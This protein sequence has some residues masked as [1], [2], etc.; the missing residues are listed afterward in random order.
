MQSPV[1]RVR[2]VELLLLTLHDGY[3]TVRGSIETPSGVAEGKR[4][5]C[6]DCKR[7]GWLRTRHGL[8][9]CLLC[10]GTGWKRRESEEPWDEYV[11]L[12]TAEAAQ[13]PVMPSAPSPASDAA[14]AW[15]R[16]RQAHDAKGSYRELR[17]ALEA[18]AHARPSWHRL[19]L[20]KLVYQETRVFTEGAET[21]ILLGVGWLAREMRGPVRVPPWVM[22]QA[23]AEERRDSIAALRAVGLTNGQIGQRLGMS[24]KAVKRK[25]KAARRRRM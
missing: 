25:L 24:P 21:A 10:D 15:E 1:E 2:R 7:Q 18:L 3:P 22:E 19:V 17:R 13:L 14:Y 6:L 16:A 8:Q 12:P 9:L 4:V 5:P 11:N 23:R 20:A